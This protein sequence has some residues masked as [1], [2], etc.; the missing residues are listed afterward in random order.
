VIYA[1]LAV[2]A[3][4]YAAYYNRWLDRHDSADRSGGSVPLDYAA[5]AVRIDRDTR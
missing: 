1:L 3:L 4:A 2:G 5:T